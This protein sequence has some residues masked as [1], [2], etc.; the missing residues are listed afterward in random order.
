[1]V[2]ISSASVMN[3]RNKETIHVLS[4]HCTTKVLI[5]QPGSP[6]DLHLCCSHMQKA[7]F[8]MTTLLKDNPSKR[9]R[10]GDLVT[11][12]AEIPGSIKTTFLLSCQLRFDGEI[13]KIIP[14]Y[15]LSLL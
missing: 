1:M 4:K 9:I 3:L 14:K 2:L 13:R 6:A 12:R 5:S 7:I 10:C 8:L 15:D 11:K